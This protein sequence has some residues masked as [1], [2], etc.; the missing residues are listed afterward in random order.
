MR[1]ELSRGDDGNAVCPLTVIVDG[2]TAL[3][4]G[5]HTTDEAIPVDV[6]TLRWLV[7]VA[8]PAA[9]SAMEAIR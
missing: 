8:G 2:H 4:Q 7:L 3:L 5:R 9:L 6:P 1:L